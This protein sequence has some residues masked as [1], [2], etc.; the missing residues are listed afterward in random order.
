MAAELLGDND[1][2]SEQCEP[3]SMTSDSVLGLVLLPR[4][5]LMDK[6]DQGSVEPLVKIMALVDGSRSGS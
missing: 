2:I 3:P 4:T 5:E 6:F 1:V